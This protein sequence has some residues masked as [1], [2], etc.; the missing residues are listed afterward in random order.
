MPYEGGLVQPLF[1]IWQSM[2]DAT[3]PGKAE[4]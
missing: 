4:I 2:S 3:V 1:Y